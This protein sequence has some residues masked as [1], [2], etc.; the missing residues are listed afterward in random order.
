MIINSLKCDEC[1]KVFNA[2]NGGYHIYA[3]YGTAH[4]NIAI[5]NAQDEVTVSSNFKQ[6]CGDQCLFKM[7]QRELDVFKGAII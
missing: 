1:R 2:E 3:S 7:I 5:C 6:A 4:L